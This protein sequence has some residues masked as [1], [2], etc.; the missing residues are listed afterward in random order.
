MV[1]IVG[2]GF[3]AP[4]SFEMDAALSQALRSKQVRPQ[5]LESLLNKI[6]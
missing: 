1:L 5:S 6:H 3:W 4:L 2:G